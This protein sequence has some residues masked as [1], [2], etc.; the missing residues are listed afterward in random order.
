MR[1]PLLAASWLAVRPVR[2]AGVASAA[3]LLVGVTAPWQDSGHAIPVMHG[4]VLLVACVVALCTDDPAAEVI[5]ATPYTRNVRTLA[6]IGVGLAVAVPTYLLAA[7][8]AETRFDPAPQLSLGAEAVAY[9]LVAAALGT[10]LRARGVHSPGYPTALTLLA[11]TFAVD[12]L[13]VQ[14][15]M[16]NPQTWGPPLEAALIRW[17]AVALLAVGVL[18]IALRDPAAAARPTH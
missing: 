2:L 16:I 15:L 8:V 13:P 9:L 3:A 11:L 14:Y 5:A 1:T 17:G 10:A 12:Q 18:A 4:V 6:R 7:A